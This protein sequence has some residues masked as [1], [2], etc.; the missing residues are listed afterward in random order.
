[1]EE[2]EELKPKKFGYVVHPLPPHPPMPPLPPPPPGISMADWISYINSYIDVRARQLYDKL[3]SLVQQAGV[4]RV[5]YTPSSNLGANT[6]EI[7]RLNVDGDVTEVIAP[8]V[9][10]NAEGERDLANAKRVATIVGGGSNGQNVDIFCEDPDGYIF[11]EIL[12][13]DTHQ[14]KVWKLYMKDG[15]LETEEYT[16]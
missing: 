3:K 4:Q 11:D 8:V 14:R 12:L 9:N 6:K 15:L 13:Q 5:T 7:G 1:M 2:K 16:G 10:V